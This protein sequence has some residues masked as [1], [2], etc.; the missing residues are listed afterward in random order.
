MNRKNKGSAFLF[1][2]LIMIP[3]MLFSAFFSTDYAHYMVAKHEV[4]TVGESLAMS[5]VGAPSYMY[6]SNGIPISIDQNLASKNLCD[7]YNKM[8]ENDNLATTYHIAIQG[9]YGDNCQNSIIFSP[10]GRIASIFLLYKL[11]LSLPFLFHTDCRDGCSVKYAKFTS[12]VCDSQNLPANSL[13]KFCAT[14]IK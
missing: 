8:L 7:L 5:I 9:R 11:D 13:I 10:D 6:D 3:I 12:M 4:D 1:F 2:I 14:P